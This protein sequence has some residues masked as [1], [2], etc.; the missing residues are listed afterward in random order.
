VITSASVPQG[1]NGPLMPRSTRRH[2]TRSSCRARARS[3]PGTTSFSRRPFARPA[4][5]R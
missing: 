2:P 1:P 4:E 3:M 5:R